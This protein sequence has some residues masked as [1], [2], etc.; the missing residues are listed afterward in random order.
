[1]NKQFIMF[2]ILVFFTGLYLGILRIAIPVFEKQLNIAI[3]L[4]LLLP[5]VAFGFVKGAFNFFAGKLSDDLGRKRVLIIGWIVA[6]MTVPLFLSVNI[7]TVIIISIL[8]AINQAFTWTTTVTSQIDIS[9]KLRAGLATG[10]NE[11]SGYLG[12]SFGSLFA[13]YLF[14]VSYIL[15]SIICL[16]A[17]IS[18]FTVMETKKLITIN[19]GS[20]KEDNNRVN[21]FSITKISIAGHLE[22]F[23][24]SSFFILIPTFLLLQHYTLFLI[25]ITVSSYTF[26]WSLSQPLFGY[27]ADIY[28]R[29]RE[30]LVIGFLLMFIGFIKYSDFPILFSILE[31]IGMGMVYPNLIAF[32]NDKVNESVRGKA[33]GYYRLY[34][35]SGYGVAGL[36]LPLLYSFYGYEYTL[37]IVGILQVVALLLIARS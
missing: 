34:R 4:S 21:Y 36:L 14:N 18:S 26:T 7:Y 37:L 10:I 22:K 29:R 32:V 30:I 9:G 6:L 33:L 27:L 15:I 12:V 31:G 20:L 19:N 28:N 23:V 13:S 16:I 24:D 1:M 3:T 8:L 11:M 35:D 5:L 25:G 2:T 17:L